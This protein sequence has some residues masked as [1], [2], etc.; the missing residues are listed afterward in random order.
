MFYWRPFAVAKS[1]AA[2]LPRYDIESKQ[3]DRNNELHPAAVHGD[4]STP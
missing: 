2:A 4:R 3:T 1:L